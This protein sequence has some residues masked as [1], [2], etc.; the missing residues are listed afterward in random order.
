MTKWALDYNSG[1]HIGTSDYMP[2][3]LRWDRLS[4]FWIKRYGIVSRLCNYLKLLSR[5]RA[6][7]VVGG[8]LMKGL[9]H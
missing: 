6:E 8:V 1:S 4:L 5:M 9:H 3:A 7:P 2:G